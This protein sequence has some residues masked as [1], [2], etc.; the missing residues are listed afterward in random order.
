MC[1]CAQL[2][3]LSAPLS[4]A[5]ITP[6]H[7][8]RISGSHPAHTPTSGGVAGCTSESALCTRAGSALPDACT[9]VTIRQQGVSSRQEK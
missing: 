3:I 4:Q 2:A 7:T 8:T 5:Y 6:T 9:A 1:T